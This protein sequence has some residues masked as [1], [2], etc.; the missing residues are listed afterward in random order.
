MCQSDIEINSHIE[1]YLNYYC[2]LS[3]APGFA[4][5]LK[6]QWG[7]GKTWFIE[8][9]CQKLKESNQEVLYISLYGMRGISEI[10]DNFFQLLHPIRSSK[11]MAITG[12]ILK[13]LLKGALKIDLNRDNKEEGTWNIQIPEINLPKRLENINKSIIIFDD[14][15]R[16]NI[17]L[18]T[19]LGYINYFVEH[20][21]L[22]VVIIANE[23]ELN[24]NTSYKS[25]KEKLVGMTF[26]I[27]LDFE[28]ALKNFI[29]QIENSNAK[30]ILNENSLLIRD[31]YNKAEYGNLRNLKQ[32]VLDF[33]RIFEALPEKAKNESGISEDILKL[34][35]VFSIEIKRASMLP[36]DIGNLLEEYQSILSNQMDSRYGDSSAIQDKGTE[37]RPLQKVLSR[38]SFLN[39]QDPFPSTA[40]WQ[41]FFDRGIIDTKELEQSISSSKYFQ[42]E[43]TPDWVKLWYYSDICDDDFDAL[44]EK[45]NINFNNRNF[46]EL[47]VLKH[48][49]GMFLIFSEAGIYAKSKQEILRD[50]KKYIDD[51]K[52]KGQ[53]EPLPQSIPLSAAI[54]NMLGSYYSLGFHGKEFPEFKEFCFYLNQA[55][56]ENRIE[57]M[58]EYAQSVLDA[59]NS[60]IWKFH[61]MICLGGLYSEDLSEPRYH[62]IPILSHISPTSFIRVILTLANEDRERVFWSI[63]ERYEYDDIADKLLEEL[64]W[65]KNIQVL[66]LEEVILRKG[67]ISG[68]CLERLNINYLQKSIEK[69]AT[70]KEKL[71]DTQ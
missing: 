23:E 33:Q 71:L 68:F 7:S 29:D 64:D 49:F 69:L 56:M 2:G 37:Q 27:S 62:K 20:Q 39:L 47:G 61:R 11:G 1:T 67:K 12:I 21:G 18:N 55:Q 46:I 48:V 60:D 8:R 36:Q 17:D 50:S 57:K 10:E 38:Y 3:H 4:V 41:I 45:I 30:R 15:E 5:L 65:L 9:Y 52:N 19:L 34:L 51:L 58:S 24:K 22:K 6:G 32:I 13:G 25:T 66:L 42:N 44:L 26:E 40:W 54:G 31:L 63:S 16:C 14:L 59:M 53:L 28:G 43:N 70:K 35:V